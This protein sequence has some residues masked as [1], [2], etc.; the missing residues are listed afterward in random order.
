MP[1]S[2][3]FCHDL[4]KRGYCTCAGSFGDCN[5]TPTSSSGGAT[6]CQNC[7]TDVFHRG[8][9]GDCE[10]HPCRCHP[11]ARLAETLWATAAGARSLLLLPVHAGATS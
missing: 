3:F 8:A 4:D 1:K 5:C 11:F 7:G 2:T 6:S 9:C 10:A